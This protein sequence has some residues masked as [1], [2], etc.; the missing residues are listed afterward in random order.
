MGFIDDNLRIIEEKIGVACRESGRRSDEITIVAI[1]KTVA[2]ELII[3]ARRAGLKHFGENKVQE[4]ALKIPKTGFG[5]QS[6][7][8]AI[9][10]MVG[11]LQTNKAKTAAALF[12]R[13]DS[14]DSL[15]LAES[16][17]KECAKIGRQMTVLLEINSSGEAAKFG[18]APDKLLPDARSIAK[19]DNLNL[20]GLMTVGPLTDDPLRIDESF[21]LTRE[22]Y[23]QMQDELGDSIKILSMG[24]SA[25]YEKAIKFGATEVRIGTAIFG[26]RDYD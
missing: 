15:K 16:L 25:D 4:A 22:Y 23:R 20:A 10:H 3:E 18:Y 8:G 14:V 13:I 5:R 12:D 19:M 11:H 6:D 7:D 21:A 1:S 26:P 17:S 9:W 2:P 24:M